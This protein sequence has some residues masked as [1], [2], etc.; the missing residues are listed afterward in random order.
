MYGKP[1]KVII[2]EMPNQ[3]GGIA[4]VGGAFGKVCGS[5]SP[6]KNH[7][8]IV[9]LDQLAKWGSVR[10]SPRN[11]IHFPHTYGMQFCFCFIIL[12]SWKISF[13]KVWEKKQSCR[14]MVIGP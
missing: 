3:Q 9:R 8:I 10:K 7:L 12:D 5:P 1:G 6:S 13:I 4:V 14:H 2:F 11:E